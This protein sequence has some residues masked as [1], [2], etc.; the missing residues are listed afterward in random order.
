[1]SHTKSL[2]WSSSSSLQPVGLRLAKRQRLSPVPGFSVVLS[3]WAS[4]RDSSVICIRNGSCLK[5]QTGKRP[6]LG[7]LRLFS[8]TFRNPHHSL[9]INSITYQV[10]VWQVRVFAAHRYMSA[11]S[12][13]FSTFPLLLKRR[14]LHFATQP[15]KLIIPNILTSR[16][17]LCYGVKMPHG[18]L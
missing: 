9:P 18:N 10:E 16:E 14:A 1:M 5:D 6:M 2:Q 11:N 15:L 13:F 7:G 3:I 4:S 8:S 12:L 17:L